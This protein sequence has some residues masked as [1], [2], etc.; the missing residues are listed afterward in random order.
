MSDK[1]NPKRRISES[2]ARRAIRRLSIE[3][4][5]LKRE[6]EALKRNIN[7]ISTSGTS[8]KPTDKYHSSLKHHADS[9]YIF[10]KRSYITHLWAQL[11]RTSFFSVYK[12]VINYIRRYTFITTS[13]K[14]ASMVFLFIETT[15]L[16]VISTSA[17]IVSL[18]LTLLLSQALM[19]L[20]FFTR[21]R[22]NERNTALL[23]GKRVTVFFPPKGRA[24]ERDSFFAHF[25][26][27]TASG[28]DCIC[29]IVSPYMLKSTGLDSSRGAYYISRND[30]QNILLVRRHYYFTLRKKII[31]KHSSSVTEVY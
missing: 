14:V 26:T 2:D 30:G 28:E 7:D 20:T 27:D 5:R 13:L 22:H 4:R 23:S 16:L 31:D 10:R 19:V 1:N 15:A 17:L 25:V 9:E 8:L 11:T 18:V 3:N 24:F 29:V 6:N 21:R 12:R